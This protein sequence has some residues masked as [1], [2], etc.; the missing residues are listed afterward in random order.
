VIG[1]PGDTL[2]VRDGTVILN[3][4]PVQRGPISTVS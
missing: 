3:G 4:K 2:A 1:L